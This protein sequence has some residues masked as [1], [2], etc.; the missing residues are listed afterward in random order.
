LSQFLYGYHVN[1]PGAFIG[2]GY[3]LIFGF[4]F[5]SVTA[6]I[7]NSVLRLYIAILKRRAEFQLIERQGFFPDKQSISGK[8]MDH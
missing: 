1:P 5:G 6:W 3:A 8:D 2:L 4:I 7:R